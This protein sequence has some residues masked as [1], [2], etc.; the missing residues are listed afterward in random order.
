LFFPLPVLL[1]GE[2]ATFPSRELPAPTKAVGDW[3][4][5]SD[6]KVTDAKKVPLTRVLLQEETAGHTEGYE[7][8]RIIYQKVD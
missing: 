4:T 1:A 5:V 8:Q 2:P 6:W 7:N 3:M